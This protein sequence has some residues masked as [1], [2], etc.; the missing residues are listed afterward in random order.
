M[1]RVWMMAL[2]LLPLAALLLWSASG[3]EPLTKAEK[4]VTI[5]ERDELF[6]DSRERQIF[7]RGPVLGYYIGLK[8]A[9][10]GTTAVALAGIGLTLWLTRRRGAVTTNVAASQGAS[11]VA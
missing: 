6:G 10:A 11:D 8:D 9:V 3:R 1:M 5:V 7:V 4:N 2:A